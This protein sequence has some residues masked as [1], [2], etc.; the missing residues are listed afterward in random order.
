[1]SICFRD[2]REVCIEHPFGGDWGQKDVTHRAASRGCRRVL[3]GTG[4]GGR[5]YR[6]C[7]NDMERR[8]EAE[9]LKMWSVGVLRSKN[10]SVTPTPI[11]TMC[12]RTKTR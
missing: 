1:M 3:A 10:G 6:R 9:G 11:K 2:V 12:G 8:Q 7:P 4:R 5:T